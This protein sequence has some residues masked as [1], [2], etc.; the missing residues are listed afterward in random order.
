LLLD[1]SAAFD[2]VDHQIFLSWLEKR[3]G[4]KGKVL[5]WFSSYL[6]DR[7]QFVKVER[8]KTSNCYDLKYGVPQGSF[9]DP[10]C[11]CFIRPLWLTSFDNM[12]LTFICMRMTPNYI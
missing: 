6:S 2:T 1:L 8:Q 5:E 7:T 9:W 11:L 3:F 4:F 12:V 10:C